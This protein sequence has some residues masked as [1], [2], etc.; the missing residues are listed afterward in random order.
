[1]QGELGFLVLG[2]IALLLWTPG[3][4]VTAVALHY[5]RRRLARRP[6]DRWRRRGYIVAVVLP[7]LVVY[8]GVYTAVM[9]AL[10]D[11]GVLP[12]GGP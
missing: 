7:I 1:M 6:V 10:F 12:S 9:F 11:S 3:L 5:M 4:A 2:L 8:G